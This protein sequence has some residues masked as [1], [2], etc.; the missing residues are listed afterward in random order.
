ME[1]SWRQ[2]CFRIEGF[3]A[4]DEIFLIVFKI[5]LILYYL[6]L[7]FLQRK[8]LSGGLRLKKVSMATYRFFTT[9]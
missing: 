3:E 5:I 8:G 6:K 9:N 1:K 2:I 7:E 4:R